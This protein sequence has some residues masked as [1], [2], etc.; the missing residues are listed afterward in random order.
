[1]TQKFSRG[2]TTT[3]SN[4]WKIPSFP[5]CLYSYLERTESQVSDDD[6]PS[7]SK[8]TYCYQNK[9]ICIS[10]KNFFFHK[11]CLPF[12]EPI[13]V[14]VVFLNPRKKN[15]ELQDKGLGTKDSI[16]FRLGEVWDPPVRILTGRCV[17]SSHCTT[18]LSAKFQRPIFKLSRAD[19]PCR[20]DLVPRWAW[21]AN[22]GIELNIYLYIEYCYIWAGIAGSTIVR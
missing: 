20:S 6:Y 17:A 12:L 7:L 13:V 8:L 14:V 2:L 4:L 22:I 9:R 16:V 19:L 18:W 11:V 3:K 5:L 1:M 10:M 21:K 15:S